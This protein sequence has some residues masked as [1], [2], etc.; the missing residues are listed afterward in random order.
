MNSWPMRSRQQNPC[1]GDSEWRLFNYQRRTTN[2]R[3]D[4]LSSAA[5]SLANSAG[6]ARSRAPSG[7]SA[8]RN[9]ASKTH[10]RS[11]AKNRVLRIVDLVTPMLIEGIPALVGVGIVVVNSVYTNYGS[12]SVIAMFRQ[13]DGRALLASGSFQVQLLALSLQL[14]SI[15]I[16]G[17]ECTLGIYLLP[18]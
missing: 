8:R 4:S 18:F 11:A 15:S 7:Q 14:L 16:G 13:F 10:V 9:A 17:I 6:T 5:E 2:S 3:F 1:R 12:R